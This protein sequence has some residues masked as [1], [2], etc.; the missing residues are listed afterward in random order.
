ML[1]TSLASRILV[2]MSEDFP[3]RQLMI[4]YNWTSII[5]TSMK[6]I[7]IQKSTDLHPAMLPE[8]LG[9][10]NKCLM[11]TME[12]WTCTH[13]RN[14]PK[15][16][17]FIKNITDIE[18]STKERWM[19]RS[20]DFPLTTFPEHL[21][22]DNQYHTEITETWTCTHHKNQPRRMTPRRILRRRAFTKNITSTEISPKER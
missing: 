10:D 20:M 3:C 5:K 12:I 16:R 21:M 18:T 19:R 13:H 7:W 2:K 8:F 17:A 1:K 11:E 6:E 15:R 22:R 9:T 4:S 14:N